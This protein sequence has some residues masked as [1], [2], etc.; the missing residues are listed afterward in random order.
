MMDPLKVRAPTS[1]RDCR[2][3][4]V[5]Q[6]N[7]QQQPSIVTSEVVEL[8]AAHK[9]TNQ[10]QEPPLSHQRLWSRRRC[11]KQPTKSKHIRDCRAGRELPR[12]RVTLCTPRTTKTT[13]TTTTTTTITTRLST[14]RRKT[15]FWGIGTQTITSHAGEHFVGTCVIVNSSLR[16]VAALENMMFKS[17]V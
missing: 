11:T 2:A 1:F 16:K 15:C 7:Q 10:R 3:G 17:F 8:E 13:T 6:T 9:T 12:Q 4:G 5:P 14:T